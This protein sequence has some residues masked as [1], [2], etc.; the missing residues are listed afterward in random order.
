MVDDW[1]KLNDYVAIDVA[2]APHNAMRY[3]PFWRFNTYK[4]PIVRVR[5]RD[6]AGNVRTAWLRTGHWLLGMLVKH[7]D[8]VW[9]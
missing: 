7:I 9:E 3:G 4:Q 5:L 2:I 8:V 6:R 1:C